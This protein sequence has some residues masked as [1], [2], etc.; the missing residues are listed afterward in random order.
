MANDM[1][2]TSSMEARVLPAPQ[3]SIQDSLLESVSWVCD[4]YDL[5]KT[6]EALT[7]G[8]PKGG[9][10]SPSLALAALANAGLSAGLVERRAQALPLQ[11]TPMVVLRKEHGGAVLVGRREALDEN[12]KRC[13]FIS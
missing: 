12:G 9:L 3:P 6:P 4:Y 5:G 7:A 13:F 8:L 1:P 10:L 11:L 2:V